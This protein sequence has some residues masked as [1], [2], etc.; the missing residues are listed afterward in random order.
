MDAIT[1]KLYSTEYA[2][3]GSY[4][5]DLQRNTIALGYNATTAHIL[6]SEFFAK[7]TPQFIRNATTHSKIPRSIK[8]RPAEAKALYQ[9]LL[10]TDRNDFLQNIINHLD[11]ALINQGFQNHKY[12]LPC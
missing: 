6:L 1:L 4:L 11:R 9:E 8:L 3:L 2:A 12:I 7:K 5:D 10:Y